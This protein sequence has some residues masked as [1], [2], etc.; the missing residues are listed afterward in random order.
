MAETDLKVLQQLENL[1]RSRS[2]YPTTRRTSSF[3]L[4]RSSDATP[5]DLDGPRLVGEVARSDRRGYSL[6]HTFLPSWH[7]RRKPRDDPEGDDA[8]G[9]PVRSPHKLE[10]E[11]S[12]LKQRGI[13]RWKPMRALAHLV[14]HRVTCLFSVEVVAVRHLP[15][16]VDRL[17]LS[18]TVRK[19]ETKDGAVK[20]MP[21]QVL[22]GSAEFEET[23]FIRC[24]LYCSGG[25]G[26]GK[27][28]R[29]EPRL[30]LIS[31]M[32]VDAPHLEI[33]AS[34]VDLSSL[35]KESIQKNLE[36]QRIRQWDMAFP[37]SVSGKA[38]GGEMVLK[39]AFQI[40]DDG[41]VG[42][43][44]QTESI[45]P[46]REKLSDFS[47]SRK[48]RKS[49]VS[50]SSQ[51]IIQGDPF[52]TS[53]N[54]S[55]FGNPGI[56]NFIHPVLQKV[57]PEQDV[58]EFDLPEFEVI[59]KGAEIQHGEVEEE[60]VSGNATG[61]TSISS[62]VVKEVVH[63]RAHGEVKEF[64]LITAK[65]ATDAV[66]R[67]KQ[68][69][70]RRLLDTEEEM[71]TREFLQML[72]TEDNKETK[73]DDIDLVS[74][75]N[76][77]ARGD[78]KDE[79]DT[80]AFIPDL[81]KNLGCVVQTKDGGYLASMNPFDVQVSK[82][83]T[84]KLVMQVSK[85]LIL[86][87][88]KLVTGFDVFQKLAAIGLEEMDS[89]LLSLTNMDELWGKTAEQV[90]FEGI[91]STI[92]SGRNKE[93]ASSSVAK[94]ITVVK[95]IAI[96]MNKG[97]KERIMT[98]FWSVNEEPVS[99]DEILTFAL[100]KMEIMAVDALKV[101]AEMTDDEAPFDASPLIEKNG[102]S[103]PLNSAIT[104]EDWS[105]TCSTNRRITMLVVIQLRNPSR[106]YEAVGAPIIAAVQAMALNDGKIDDERRFKL[107]SLHVG[108]LKLSSNSRSVWDGEKQR[109]TAV[110]WLVENG[111][112]KAGRRTKQF[113]GKRTQDFV[114]SISSRFTAGIW[115]R[116][117]RNPNVKV[118]KSSS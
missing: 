9:G 6:R 117:V 61:R 114:W 107:T 21:S 97:R 51:R 12:D 25:A 47:I 42:I 49:S 36:G 93:G 14:M 94:S 68:H 62:E 74:S 106:S 67:T 88:E 29:F 38:A 4:A 105:M 10:P 22:Q 77:G 70:I 19:K 11:H 18:V 79:E 32:A 2:R 95:K 40:M 103:N 75:S 24:H 58:Q 66:K 17:R 99:V 7:S 16:S 48:Q 87:D 33:G 13:W 5:A 30:F 23:L 63:D 85:G 26:T 111:L 55:D 76:L 69:I 54:N 65:D 86:K 37:L 116:Q 115:L 35:V 45:T 28:L 101:Q 100:Q 89:K 102:T 73:H 34:I 71:A 1:A 108:G 56:S 81:G 59:D 50:A 15:A 53:L 112:G 72:E 60:A 98:G 44:K 8:D 104:L 90:A 113:H 80:H 20:T 96:A 46:N 118:M 31:A 57:N 27:P 41:G 109:L 52:A 91:A 84:P 43:Y 110:Q 64:E 78:S 83:E 39:L 82:N 3:T 92:I